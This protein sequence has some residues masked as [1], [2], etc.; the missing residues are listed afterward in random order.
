MN[1]GSTRLGSRNSIPEGQ[2]NR[3]ERKTNAAPGASAASVRAVGSQA[4]A[5]YF[6]APGAYVPSDSPLFPSTRS[7]YCIQID[8]RHRLRAKFHPR[9]DLEFPLTVP[10]FAAKAF[11]RTRV[12]VWSSAILRNVP[13]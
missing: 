7:T 11:F 9:T 6:R 12:D 5:F 4:L 8:A 1:E 10:L 2:P 3:R 13:D